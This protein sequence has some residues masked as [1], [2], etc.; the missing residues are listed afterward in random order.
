MTLPLALWDALSLLIYFQTRG[1]RKHQDGRPGSPCPLWQVPLLGGSGCCLELA[2]ES[3]RLP[4][5][6]TLPGARHLKAAPSPARQCC[7][8]W[9]GTSALAVVAAS[10]TAAATA[11]ACRLRVGR[12]QGLSQPPSSLEALGL[13]V[14]SH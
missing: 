14:S 5:A 10:Q 3:L 6:T 11:T 1:L 9:T 12:H 2:D 8:G 4:G 7:R 13:G